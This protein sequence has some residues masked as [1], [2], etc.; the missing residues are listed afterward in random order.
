MR[1]FLAITVTMIAFAANS[2]L[3]RMAIGGGFIDPSGFALVRVISGALVLGMIISLRGGGLPLLRRR[4]IPGA[5]SLAVYLVGFS[6]AYLTLDAGLGALIL[7]GVVQV[8]MFLHGALHGT[9]PTS[10]QLTGGV[11]AFLGLLCALWP[12]PGGVADPI[13]AAL[14][15]FAGLG[16]AA[17]SIIGRAAQDP[18]AATSANFLLSIPILL[19]LLVGTGLTFSATGIALG[20]LC[21]GLTSGL[22][23]ALWYSV[24]PR[25]QGATAAIVQLSVPVIAILAGAVLLNE[26]IGPVVLFATLMVV[27]GIGWSVTGSGP[28]N[29]RKEQR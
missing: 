3:T 23:Y 15:V 13:G 20:I 19:I 7:F 2:V 11:V 21:G 17:Y 22:G 1:L 18:L 12:G 14:M 26:E 25:I 8:S 27:G 29:T 28:R 4:R 24:L 16:W 9:G 10:R 6:L 5:V